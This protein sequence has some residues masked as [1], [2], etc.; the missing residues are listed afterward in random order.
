MVSTMAGKQPK[1]GHQVANL[2]D[3]S[4]GWRAAAYSLAAVAG[5]LAVIAWH[6]ADEVRVVLVP[7]QFSRLAQGR[8]PVTRSKAYLALLA[9][10]DTATLLD[11]TPATVGSQFTAF[12]DRCA[13]AL[14]ARLDTQMLADSKEYA[15]YNLTESFYVR[16][17]VFVPPAT[18]AI[19]GWLDRY[20]GDKRVMHALL[21]YRLTYNH[22][23]ALTRLTVEKDTH[24]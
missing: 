15:S 6:S 9:R 24:A 1:Y 18:I 16:K 8:V 5:L 12:L 22:S 10:A 2:H 23:F 11:W 21:T 17:V 13:P 7:P 3:A 4:R 14:Y 20:S 19:T